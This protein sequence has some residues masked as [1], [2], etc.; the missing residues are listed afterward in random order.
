MKYLNVPMSEDLL[1]QLD[2]YSKDHGIYIKKIVELALIA[3]L[4]K[5]KK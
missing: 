5:A 2:T 1:K 3:Y 4:K